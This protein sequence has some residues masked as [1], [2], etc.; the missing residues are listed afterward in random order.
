MLP[1]QCVGEK[2]A[3]GSIGRPD[4]IFL[5]KAGL[6][7]LSLDLYFLTIVWLSVLHLLRKKIPCDLVTGSKEIH[8]QLKILILV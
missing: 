4:F 2:L 1:L 6:P 3:F 5:T 7:C 8:L